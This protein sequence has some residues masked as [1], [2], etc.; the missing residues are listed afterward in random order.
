MTLQP[1]PAH[2]EVAAA[3]VA[4][5][6]AAIAGDGVTSCDAADVEIRRAFVRGYAQQVSVYAADGEKV[7][8]PPHRATA[9]WHPLEVAFLIFAS[10]PGLGLNA[11]AIAHALG[12]SHVSVRI[13]ASRLGVKRVAA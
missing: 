5:A 10:E 11:P 1:P 4:G 9:N 3:M 12:R 7:P 6:M 2:D 13:K 8:A